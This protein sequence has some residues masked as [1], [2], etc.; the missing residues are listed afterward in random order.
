MS[1][2]LSGTG[3]IMANGGSASGNDGGGGGRVAIYYTSDSGFNLTNNITALGGAGPSGA[4]SAGT[5][6]L[7][8]SGQ[9]SQLLINNSGAKPGA[10]TPLGVV[11]D[12]VFQ[13]DNLVIVGTN[14]VAATA[15]GAPIEANSVTVID[16]AVLTHQAATTNQVYSLDMTITNDLVLDATSKIDVSALGYQPG[17]TVGNTTNGGATKTA[18]GSYGGVGAICCDSTNNAVYGDYRNPN[19]LGSG[20]GDYSTGAAGGGLVRITAGSAQINGEILANGGV[21]YDGG[22]GGGIYLNVGALSGAGTIAANGGS[23]AGNNGGGG[24]RVAVYYT[25]DS[26]FNLTNSITAVGGAGPSGAGSAGTVYL[27]QNGQLG[28]LLINNNG[29]CTERVD[30]AGAS[31][32]HRLSGGQF[33]NHRNQHC[34]GDRHRRTDPG[35]FGDDFGRRH[36]DAAGDHSSEH[37]FVTTNDRQQPANRPHFRNKRFW[38]GIPARVHPRQHHRWRGELHCGWF[39]WRFGGGLLRFDCKHGLRGLP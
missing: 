30:A 3:T 25:A 15:S 16:G 2:A 6:Y 35:Q 20:S 4:G 21:N 10:L 8:Q 5:V 23:A 1:E 18:G 14:T 9:L 26:G 27:Q 13:V 38:N 31:D 17:Y 19:D 24:G 7:Q 22:S 32:G 28:Q 33:G 11:T 34:G 36:F 12:T 29:S 39:L 37:L